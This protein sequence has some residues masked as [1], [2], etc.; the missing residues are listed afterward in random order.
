MRTGIKEGQL[1]RV[2]NRR[3]LVEDVISFENANKPISPK[4]T[5]ACIEDDSSGERIE[6]LWDLELDAKILETRNSFDIETL[7]LPSEFRVYLHAVR[8]N[9]ITSMDSELL[10][11]PFRAGIDL[12][13]YQLE[14]LRKALTLPRVNLFIAD[15]VGLGK[16]VE[17]GLVMQELVLRQ[18]VNFVLIVAPPAV[19]RQWQEEMEQ[20]HGKA[21][22]IIGKQRH[23][24]VG[25]VDLAFDG[26]FTR[27]GNLAK[28]H[29]VKN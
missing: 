21:E 3:W 6:V 25:T 22:L 5:L 4:V 10:Q 26:R 24:P 28:S 15:D 17:A 8:W 20:I 16:T 29:Q 23:G 13:P 1:V 12:K 7:D 19:T 9:C 11:S 2:R 27:F 18:R 14:P